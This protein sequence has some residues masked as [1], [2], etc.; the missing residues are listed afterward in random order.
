[1]GG[2]IGIVFANVVGKIKPRPTPIGEITPPTPVAMDRK[3]ILVSESQQLD[4]IEDAELLVKHRVVMRNVAGTVLVGTIVLVSACLWATVTADTAGGRNGGIM[5]I[6]VNALL[7]LCA[8][9]GVVSLQVDVW[10]AKKEL[11]VAQRA[12][13]NVLMK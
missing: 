9:S 11:R 1:M 7:A 4:A 5:G 12:H 8:F 3:R 10:D 13:R 6:V 2:G